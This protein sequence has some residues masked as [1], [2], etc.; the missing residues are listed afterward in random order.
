MKQKIKLREL[1]LKSLRFKRRQYRVLLIGLGLFA[2]VL[3]AF[4]FWFIDHAEEAIEQIVSAQS[5]GKL[6]LTI[7]KFR[8]NW[9]NNKIELND[10]IFYTTDSTG[11]S[12][13]QLS[14]KKITVKARGFLPLLFKSQLLIDSIHLYA[15]G[16]VFTKIKKKEK[17]SAAQKA[18]KDSI[19]NTLDDEFSVPKEMGRISKS[20]NEAINVLSIDK[21][22]ISGGSFA[23]ID[24]TR[25]NEAPFRVD[26]INI[27]LDNLQVDS[28]TSRKSKKK[29]LFTDNIAVQT[30]DQNIV[31]PGGRH[32]LNFKNFKVNLQNRRVEFDSCTIRGMKGD[33]SRSAFRIFFN[34]LHLTNINFDT[35]YQSEVIKADSVFCTNPKIFFDV[36]ADQK[37]T[38][39]N[40]KRV[41]RIDELVQRLIGDVML[42]YVV[43]KD[44]EIDI[45]TIKKGKTSTFSS[46]NNDL[47]LQGL[48]IRQ[49]YERP[50]KVQRLFMSLHD[51][52]TVLQDGRYSIAFDSV[53]FADDAINLTRFTFKEFRGGSAVKSIS[54][55]GFQLK[56]MSW[57]SLLYDN[58]FNAQS[59]VFYQ[60]VIHYALLKKRSDKSKSIFQSLA[61]IGG[62]MNLTNLEIRDGDINL[63]LGKGATLRLENTNLA[64]LPDELTTSKKLK[65]IQHSVKALSFTKGTFTKG[66]TFVLLNNVNL[67]EDKNGIRAT[68]LLFRANGISANAAAIGIRNVLLDSINH[69]IS[70][71]GVSWSQAAIHISDHAKGTKPKNA[72]SPTDLQLK[73]IK[74]SN[75]SVD[76]KQGNKIIKADFSIITVDEIIKKINGKPQIRGLSLAGNDLRIAS[77]GQWFSVEHLIISDNN[78]S[79]LRNIHFRKTNETDSIR[80]DIPQLTIIPNITQ[81]INGNIFLSHLVLTEPHIVATLGRRDPV[82]QKEK[83]KAP[84]INLQSALFERPNIQLTIIN[85]NNRPSYISWNGVKEN[86]YMKLSDFKSTDKTPIEAGQMKIYLTDF[87]YLNATGRKLATNANKLNLEFNNLLVQKNENDKIEWS[88]S[89][90]I[91]SLDQIMFD[92]LGKK[93]AVLK[94]DK[95]DIRNVSLDSRFINNVGDIIKNSQLLNIADADGSFTSSKNRLSWHGLNFNHGYF[96]ADSFHLAPLQTMEEYRIAKAFNE[97]YLT[98]KTGPINGGPFDMVKYGDDSILSIGNLAISDMNLITFKDK[99][100]PDSSKKIKPLP[101]EQ[102]RRIS[103]SLDIDSL[104]LINGYVEYWELNK[105]TDTLSIIPVSALNVLLTHI[106][107]HHIGPKDSLFI[108]ASANVI[109][110]L[111]T[112]L[113]VRQSY[114]DSLSGFLMKLGTGPMDLTHFNGILV[115]MIAAEITSGKLHNLSLEA[116]ANDNYSLG[117]IRM[118]YKDVRLR[119]L[120]KKTL[121]Y[122]GF[123]NKLITWAANAFIIR[124]NNNGR[125]SPVFFERLKEKSATNFLI[126]TALSGIKSSLG[127]PGVKSKQR[128]YLRKLE[129]G[130]KNNN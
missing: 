90:S 33:S 88:T 2:T 56:G 76:V 124:H 89:A 41:E 13:Y 100:Q 98:L 128:K 113:E 62:I 110:Y 31:F 79:I 107:N 39:N 87:S 40:K 20:I 117:N 23:L 57:E 75:T 7:G 91:L 60:P 59:A 96:K 66:S 27:R 68:N 72:G 125:E 11:S 115:P 84:E 97:D 67:A 44:A 118:D 28:T 10:A 53:R 25:P 93:N 83:N 32:F 8:F 112:H 70:L 22:V 122:V 47:E 9:L 24:H 52:E 94:L 58:I 119:V 86:S 103:T 129:K 78:N 61:D 45:N 82:L 106:K 49:N 80:V 104:R 126:K 5:K 51:Y 50:V 14:S 64:V 123:L 19:S 43:V 30:S 3:I 74:G 102:I 63:N 35:L 108:N 73:D 1:Q 120:N 85:K 42:N 77:P 111:P 17:L 114:L 18:E 71:E 46:R 4:N 109:N 37:T 130:E 81:I 16:V 34:K 101:T 26:N 121:L 65:S 48:I 127:L 21:F 99:T 29:I 95:G 92:S 55:A 105:K 54:M 12:L 6:K 38:K 15:P 36:D 116:I 69:N